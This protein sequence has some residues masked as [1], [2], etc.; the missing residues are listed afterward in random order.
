VDIAVMTLSELLER[1]VYARDGRK[2]GHL[3]DLRTER[4]QDVVTE[5]IYGVRGFLE[6]IGFRKG[7]ARGFQWNR[8]VSIEADRIVIDDA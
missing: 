1:P 7:R 6:K 3:L 8:V 5:G 4:G 2:L